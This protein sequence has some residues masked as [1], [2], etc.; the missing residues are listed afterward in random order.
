VNKDWKYEY[1]KKT[2]IDNILDLLYDTADFLKRNKHIQNIQ[3]F[4]KK[5]KITKYDDKT[6]YISQ[7]HNDVFEQIA[8]TE[9]KVENTVTKKN[10]VFTQKTE[11]SVEDV[12]KALS[13]KTN[14][15]KIAT[16]AIVN[17]IMFGVVIVVGIYEACKY[18]IMRLVDF[19]RLAAKLPFR[20]LFNVLFRI[21]VIIVATG[22]AFYLHNHFKNASIAQESFDKKITALE[23]KVDEDF[24]SNENKIDKERK[25][26]DKMESTAI[27]VKHEFVEYNI[28][29]KNGNLHKGKKIR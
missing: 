12:V 21:S 18:L 6:G 24:L 29:D 8:I 11:P 5:F 13:V 1:K 9:L 4:F 16:D 2:I 28:Y 15:A 3:N 26:V 17:A 20:Q 14:Y 22:C 23:K 27:I 19:I 7:K 25:R 10:K